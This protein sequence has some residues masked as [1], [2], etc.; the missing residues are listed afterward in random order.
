[1]P[2]ELETAV[3]ALIAGECCVRSERLTPSTRILHDLG[4]DGDDAADLLRRFAQAFDVDA[5]AFRFQRHFGPEAPFHPL[6]YLYLRLLRPE[7]LRFV[8]LTV[9]D[10]VQA[11]RSKRLENPDRA[12]V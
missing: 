6:S 10:L 11:A 7:R 5:S 2:D 8:P 12:A 9:G 4:W 1:V 3:I